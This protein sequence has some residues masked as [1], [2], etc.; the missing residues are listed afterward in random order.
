MG[1]GILD[2]SLDIRVV[3]DINNRDNYSLHSL[4]DLPE[5]LAYNLCIEYNIKLLAPR[6]YTNLTYKALKEKIVGKLIASEKNFMNFFVAPVI[7]GK[8]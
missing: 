3:K 2:K 6:K 5:E 7:G 8:N 4:A 1:K